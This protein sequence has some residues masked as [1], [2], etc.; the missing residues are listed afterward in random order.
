MKPHLTRYWLNANP[1]HPETFKQQSNQIC[2]LYQQAEELNNN[3]IHV[4]STD[5]M[6]GI[7][8]LERVY[9]TDT[10]KPNKIEFQEFEYIRHG[11]LSLIASWDVAL[12]GI[13]HSTIAPTRNEDDFQR[14]IADAIATEPF[15][16]W[17]FITDQLN[18]HKSES[19]VRLV[20]TNC[21]IDI[22]LGIK[23]K[24]GILHSMKSRAGFLTDISHRIRFVY[25]PKHSSW[26]NQIEC[27][28]SI[29]VRRLLRRGNFTSTS[30]LKHQILCFIDYFNRTFA[31]PFVW[32]F[33]GYPTPASTG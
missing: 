7:Q 30:D 25:T 29:L 5:E 16:G 24:Y 9:P 17:I 28:F 26:L 27:W 10:V 22:D 15:D 3:N 21:G 20:A 12:G 32:K 19:L 33:L 18:T 23:G 8:A 13:Y 14:H 2:Q 31:K 11:T 6:T 4:L 1:Q